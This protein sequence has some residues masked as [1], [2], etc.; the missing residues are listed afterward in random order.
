MKNCSN[1]SDT[2][3]VVGSSDVTILPQIIQVFLTLLNRIICTKSQGDSF[4]NFLLVNVLL[5]FT[6]KVEQS[7][8]NR[9][10]LLDARRRGSQVIKQRNGP[11]KI[12]STRQ[13]HMFF[14]T[15]F[16]R[17][18][19]TKKPCFVSKLYTMESRAYSRELY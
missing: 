18:N 14:H 3:R 7:S 12:K 2:T 4:S 9:P 10:V 13:R 17:S 1:R 16:S 6:V 11:C 15:Q 5:V 19:Q 8:H